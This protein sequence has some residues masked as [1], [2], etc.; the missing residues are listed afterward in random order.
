MIVMKPEGKRTFVVSINLGEGS[1]QAPEDLANILRFVYNP[2]WT[3]N[4]RGILDGREPD[5]L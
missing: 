1:N 4:M 2:S 5:K 3:S